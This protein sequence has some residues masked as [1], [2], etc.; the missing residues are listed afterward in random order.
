MSLSSKSSKPAKRTKSRTLRPYSPPRTNR[1][2][3]YMLGLSLGLHVLVLF[4]PFGLAKSK[5]HAAAPP[6]LVATLKP[7]TPPTQPELAL[8]AEANAKPNEKTRP[9]EVKQQEAKPDLLKLAENKLR[10]NLAAH[11]NTVTSKPKTLVQQAQQQ[12]KR[13]LLYPEAAIQQG[14]QGVATVRVF[15]DGQ[16]NALAARVEVSS[17]FA[18][19]DEAAVRAARLLRG[20][21]SGASSGTNNGTDN[22]AEADFL[23]PITFRLQP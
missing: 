12:I 10:P 21:Q 5:P 16:G 11:P 9:N 13:Q 15:L 19:L 8:K 6:P 17:G 3:L 7:I 1:R 4:P 20:L 18:L 2:F 14:L 23:I 22:A